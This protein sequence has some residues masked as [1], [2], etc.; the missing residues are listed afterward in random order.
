MAAWKV[1][2]RRGP[3][4]GREAFDALD[5]ALEAARESVDRTLREGRLGSVQGFREY[6]PGER[7]QCRIEVSGKGFLRGPEAGIDVMGDGSLVPYAGSFRKR[8]LEADT[9]EQAIEAIHAEL[10]GAS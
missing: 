5:D 9:L 7:V 1:T 10:G 8:W 3:E 4:V 2:T 6:G